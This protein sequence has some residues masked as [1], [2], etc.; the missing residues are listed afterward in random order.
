MSA[1]HHRTFAAGLS[2]VLLGC[3]APVGLESPT[4]RLA[5]PAIAQSPRPEPL[6]DASNW[7]A[8]TLPPR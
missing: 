3:S 1:L 2:L 8:V 6:P 7:L 4:A 5:T